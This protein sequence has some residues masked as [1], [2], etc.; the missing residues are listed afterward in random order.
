[1]SIL[2]CASVSAFEVGKGRLQEASGR[3]VVLGCC[4]YL[5][6]ALPNAAMSRN[7]L[8]GLVHF[9][10][11]TGGGDWR[12]F[13]S[14]YSGPNMV[15]CSIAD[16]LSPSSMHVMWDTYITLSCL[17]IKHQILLAEKPLNY[18]GKDQ[19][20]KDARVLVVLVTFTDFI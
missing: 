19:D 10:V 9:H 1:M 6:A 20:V 3:N 15:S 5:Y 11:Y 2:M 18:R 16:V 13:E 14:P 7:V 12:L 8:F 4:S 17:L